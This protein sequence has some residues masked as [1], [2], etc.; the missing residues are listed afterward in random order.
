M[1]GS[2]EGDGLLSAVGDGEGKVMPRRREVIDPFLFRLKMHSFLR[3]R[4]DP[5]FLG[6]FVASVVRSVGILGLPVLPTLWV[7]IRWADV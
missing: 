3:S 7:C 2:V 5:D 1:V 6:S 4:F